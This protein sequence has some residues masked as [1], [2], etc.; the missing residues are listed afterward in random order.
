M[1]TLGLAGESGQLAI[2]EYGFTCLLRHNQ[3]DQIRPKEVERR[4]RK[5]CDWIK[6]DDHKSWETNRGF[7]TDSRLLLF[8][9][10]QIIFIAIHSGQK[11]LEPMKWSAK[12][13]WVCVG[14][15]G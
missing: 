12:R 7:K 15:G 9:F 5:D 11:Y 3:S 10:R 6:E 4:R 8:K 13:P 2:D 1:N 14:G